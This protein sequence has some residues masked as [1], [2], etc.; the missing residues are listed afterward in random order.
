MPTADGL[1]DA[2]DHLRAVVAGEVVMDKALVAGVVAHADGEDVRLA[3]AQPARQERGLDARARRARRVD[4]VGHEDERL[5][6]A[7]AQTEGLL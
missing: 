3:H 7:R 4:P 1:K 2:L 6:R 5:V